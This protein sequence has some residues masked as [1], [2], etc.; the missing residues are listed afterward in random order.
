MNKLYRSGDV[1]WDIQV[2]HWNKFFHVLLH[3]MQRAA[4]STVN[5]ATSIVSR[6]NQKRGDM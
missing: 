1:Q 5:N 3:A 6:P 2:T 4:Y